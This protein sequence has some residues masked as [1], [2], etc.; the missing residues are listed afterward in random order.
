MCKLNACVHVLRPKIMKRK[1]EPYILGMDR[2]KGAKRDE[3]TDREERKE[4]KRRCANLQDPHLNAL[5][6]AVKLLV[7]LKE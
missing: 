2:E 6:L 5:Q 3:D 4:K 7:L 1:R